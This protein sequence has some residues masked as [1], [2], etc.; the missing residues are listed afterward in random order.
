MG[1]NIENIGRLGY[2]N[3]SFVIPYDTSGGDIEETLPPLRTF[4]YLTRTG[5]PLGTTSRFMQVVA[6]GNTLRLNPGVQIE[7]S[8][9]AGGTFSNGDILTFGGGGGTARVLAN[10]AVGTDGEL[11]VRMLTGPIPAASESIDNGGG[12]T[13]TV[14]DLFS[15]TIEGADSL[16]PLDI[17]AI[18]GRVSVTSDATLTWYRVA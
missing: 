5:D 10:A 2:F 16:S 13:A 15:F 6:G 17:T 18:G 12:V 14:S 11:N 9:L 8:G 3:A 4:G 7:F 1:D